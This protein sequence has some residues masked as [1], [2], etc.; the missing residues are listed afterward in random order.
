MKEQYEKSVA[1]RRKNSKTDPYSEMGKKGTGNKNSWLKGN[2]DNAKKAANARW[3]KHKENKL[4]KD[5]LN[6]GGVE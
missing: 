1:T 6:E 5:K 4:E 3:K 2:S